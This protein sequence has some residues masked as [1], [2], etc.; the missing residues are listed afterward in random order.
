[1]WA[2][3]TVLQ[4]DRVADLAGDALAQPEV[5]AALAGYLT[6]QGVASTDLDARLTALLPDAL[7]RFAPTIASGAYDAVDRALTRVL[8]NPDVQNTVTTIVERAHARAMSLLQG[9]GLRG[10]FNVD[11]GTISLN[12]LPLVGRGLTALQSI[13]LLDNVEVPTMTPGG[14]P[15][16][17]QAALEAALGR[18][19]P[20]G[21]A[22]LVVY[23]SD[24]VSNAQDAVQTAQRILVVAKR[25]LWLLI[26]VTVVLVAATIL[27]AARRS[28][29]A[30]VLALGTA[31]AMVVLR[32]AVRRV[33]EQ[34]PSLAA[35]PGGKAAVEAI[36]GGASTSLLRGAGIVLLVALVAAAVLLFV[37]HWNRGDLVLAAAVLLGAITF[38]VVGAT[39]WGL[40][41]GIVVGVA[42]PFAARRIPWT[43]AR[44]PVVA[45]T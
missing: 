35:K 31:G 6:D 28:R 21:F 44:S 24:R 3:A 27:I 17:Q 4:S 11:D 12:L 26:L 23:Q 29:A 7:D 9:D 37:R 15:V 39:I 45:G 16:Q 19:L 38:A 14:D 18:D 1:V 42:V 34:A 25:A 20:D 30:L 5:Q 32:S 41:A 40:L 8:S 22:Q 2:Q 10:G 36:L 33:V 13:G 43:A